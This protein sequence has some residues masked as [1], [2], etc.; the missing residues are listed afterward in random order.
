MKKFKKLM[1]VMALTASSFWLTGVVNAQNVTKWSDLKTCL[2]Q[3]EEAT[4]EVTGALDETLGNDI[5]VKGEKTLD[6][7]NQTITLVGHR[8]DVYKD[9]VLTIQNG[10]INREDRSINVVATTGS[11][12]TLENATL[13]SKKDDNIATLTVEGADANDETKTVVTID[14]DS[15]VIGTVAVG[16]VDGA[17]TAADGAT[18]NVYGTI[19]NQK[20]T[21]KGDGITV[22]GK[23]VQSTN[24]PVINIYDG[25]KVSSTRQALYAAGY[26]IWNIEGGTFEGTEAFGIKA[27]KITIEDGIFTA[28]G[29]FTGEAQANPS[30]PEFTG[31]ALSITNTYTE[32]NGQVD[33]TIKDGTFTS[34][35]GFALYEGNTSEAKPMAIIAK[36]N[37]EHAVNS[38][39][40]VDGT[41]I[42]KEGA[43]SIEDNDDTVFNKFIQGGT[44][45][46]TGENKTTGIIAA[47]LATNKVQRE[48]GKVGTPRN[49]TL[50]ESFNG[51]AAG[52]LSE[53]YGTVTIG[54]NNSKVFVDDEITLTVEPKAGYAVS[55]IEV[56][57]TSGKVIEVSEDNKFT[58]PD[59]DIIVTVYYEKSLFTVTVTIGDEKIEVPANKG[60]TLQDV[61]N[62]LTSK[63]KDILEFQDATGKKLELTTVIEEDMSIV[64]VLKEQA[65]K[66]DEPDNNLPTGDHA[67]VYVLAGVVGLGIM[68]VSLNKTYYKKN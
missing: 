68:G 9:A 58:M 63:G 52:E 22:N 61:F 53:N 48:D 6:L 17:K 28:N 18:L 23:I 51:A 32:K 38:I 35:N 7:G 1:G 26:G 41:F 25:A 60:Q 46:A 24:A 5:V 42:G 15:K 10:T 43:I 40:I 49:I 16:R 39:K 11:T 55:K 19:I 64:A 57:T 62:Y 65:D 45:E 59:E 4:C 30:G 54:G 3:T 13:E 8:I 50:Q 14:K 2:E 67:V 20:T 36:A 29:S 44:F 66:D 21:Y 12:L 37:G 56:K 33:L 31:A 27:G 34:T 47:Y